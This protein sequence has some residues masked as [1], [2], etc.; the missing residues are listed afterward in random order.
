MRRMEWL[1][2]G[3]I[4]YTPKVGRRTVRYEITAGKWHL[5]KGALWGRVVTWVARRGRIKLGEFRTC[6]EAQ[7]HCEKDLQKLFDIAEQQRQA[8]NE[9]RR[10]KKEEPVKVAS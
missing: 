2:C 10:K 4:N 7:K 1:R 5:P 3:F 6:A 9:K 8:K